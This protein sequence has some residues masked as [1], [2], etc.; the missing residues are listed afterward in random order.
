M[1]LGGGGRVGFFDDDFD[2]ATAL[3][4]AVDAG[5]ALLT[6]CFDA[7]DEAGLGRGGSEDVVG[8]PAVRA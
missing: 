4:V 7:M 8:A 6:G 2:G 3:P 5:A 1:T